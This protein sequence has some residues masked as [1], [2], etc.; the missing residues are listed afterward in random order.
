MHSTRASDRLG[1][2][3][4]T[5][6]CS[7]YAHSRSCGPPLDFSHLDM[8]P[9]VGKRHPLELVVGAEVVAS[10]PALSGSCSHGL[11]PLLDQGLRDEFRVC[12][13]ALSTGVAHL[14][15]SFT[16][17]VSRFMGSQGIWLVAR[18]FGVAPWSTLLLLRAVAGDVA[19]LYLWQ[20]R[21]SGP[22]LSGMRCP[23]RSFMLPSSCRR[24][25]IGRGSFGGPSAIKHR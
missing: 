5:R 25:A 6:I 16:D 11:L 1:P 15:A 10:P 8:E 18:I 14:A 19:W 7:R 13:P 9:L 2:S 24:S 4:I 22:S 3:N 20:A 23:M 17:M 12:C 21:V